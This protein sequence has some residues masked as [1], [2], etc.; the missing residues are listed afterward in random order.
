MYYDSKIL[1]K[2]L[3]RSSYTMALILVVLLA[4]VYVQCKQLIPAASK[5]ESSIYLADQS[6]VAITQRIRFSR[7]CAIYARA[8]K[9]Q[10]E[11]VVKVGSTGTVV[12]MFVV[13]K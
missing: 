3:F 5:S 13:S 2:K 4:L 10:V 9:Q 11:V 7:F 6:G 8:H 12:L 1:N